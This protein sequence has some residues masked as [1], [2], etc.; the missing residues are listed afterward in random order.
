MIEFNGIDWINAYGATLAKMHALKPLWVV[1]K[2]PP[3]GDWHGEVWEAS[4][5]PRDEIRHLM[6]KWA[7]THIDCLPRGRGRRD[8]MFFEALNRRQPVAL[9]VHNA[10]VLKTAVMET[11]RLLSE[12]GPLVVLV[13]DISRIDLRTREL[14]GFFQR[15]A[16]CVEAGI[17]FE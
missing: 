7:E 2:L 15:A 5:A 11:L 14:P 10:G 12:K 4:A 16:Y 1:E 13:G 3:L 17:V 8:T 6:A 9:V